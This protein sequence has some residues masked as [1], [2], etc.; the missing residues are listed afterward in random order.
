MNTR[1]FV[2]AGRTKGFTILKPG[3][4]EFAECRRQRQSVSQA[5]L[6][7]S[8]YE[9]KKLAQKKWEKINSR[10]ALRSYAQEFEAT[11]PPQSE[12]KTTGATK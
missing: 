11:T 12:A 10:E 2:E 6:E 5:I 7:A 8:E 9:I 4:A 1:E 3:V